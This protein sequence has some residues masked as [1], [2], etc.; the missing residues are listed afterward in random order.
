MH[1]ST[2]RILEAIE[3]LDLSPTMHQD[4]TDK[5]KSICEYLGTHGIEAEF[6]PQGSF[7]LGTVVRPFSRGKELTYDLDV[8]CKVNN[9]ITEITAMELKHSVGDALKGSETYRSRLAKEDQICWTIE[10]AGVGD[11]EFNLDIVPSIGQDSQEISRLMLGGLEGD[12]ASTAIS[13]TKKQPNNLYEWVPSNPKGL[14]EWFNRKNRPLFI[15]IANQQKELFFKSAA[16]TYRSIEEVPDFVVK[17]NLQRSIQFLKRH[18]DIYFFRKGYEDNKPSSIVITVLMGLFSEHVNPSISLLVLISDFTDATLLY[19]PIASNDP[20][21]ENPAEP[22]D[23]LLD[24]W[25]SEKVNGFYS[26]LKSLQQDLQVIHKDGVEAIKSVDSVLF[27]ENLGL[28]KQ[29]EI[30]D[31]KNITIQTGPWQ[32]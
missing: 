11:F 16:N 30:P 14:T 29:Y 31:A 18:R 22:G 28:S 26:W 2:E 23:N 24:T 20:I 10:Y 4:A 15:P 9:A 17:T 27:A 12:L 21:L 1:K 19:K 8:V 25:K 7:S 5:Y 6:Y 13:I 3:K 32:D